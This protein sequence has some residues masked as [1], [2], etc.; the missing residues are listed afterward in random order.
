MNRP[1]SH[2]DGPLPFLALAIL[3]LGLLL[4]GCREGS[5]GAS[6][7][8]NRSLNLIVPWAAG[9]GTDR[10]ARFVADALH[11]RVGQPVIV[12][13]RTG[14]S[15]AVGHSAGALAAPDGHTLTMATF[16]LSTMHW[17]GISK[18]AWNDFLPVAQLNG[19]AAAILVRRDAPWKNLGD[20]L[21]TIRKQPAGI[22]MSG[23]M[24]SGKRST[25]LCKERLR[26]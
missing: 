17:M 5:R 15:G 7:Y 25:C 21:E 14:G 11:R 13:N 6:S 18:L 4:S 2:Q 24:R 10:V 20:L 16:E 8:P 3:S 19:D 26:T 9:G 1:I 22:K 23:A 12:V